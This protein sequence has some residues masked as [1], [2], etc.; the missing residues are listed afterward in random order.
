[1]LRREFLKSAI[2]LGVAAT[3]PNMT[4]EPEDDSPLTEEEYEL[5]SGLVYQDMLRS[6]QSAA[7]KT[8]LRAGGV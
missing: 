5:I 6:M 3:I 2:A 4:L 7:T 1:M 8:Y